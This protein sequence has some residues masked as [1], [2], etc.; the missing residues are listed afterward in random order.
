M[1]SKYDFKDLVLNEKWLEVDSYME[2]MRKEEDKWSWYNEIVDDLELNDF[3]SREEDEL[4]EA[5]RDWIYN[6]IFD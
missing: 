5:I 2:S 1:L 4:N 6:Y 3:E